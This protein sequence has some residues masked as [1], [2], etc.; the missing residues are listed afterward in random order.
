MLS[1]FPVLHIPTAHF[2]HDTFSTSQ[3]RAMFPAYLYQKD[4]RAMPEN[5]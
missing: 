2:Q 1:P 4:E 3:S 5:L